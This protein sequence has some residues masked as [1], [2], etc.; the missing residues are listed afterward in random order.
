MA[1][2]DNRSKVSSTGKHRCVR[3]WRCEQ[4]GAR[5][6]NDPQQKHEFPIGTVHKPPNGDASEEHERDPDCGEP[7]DGPLQTW[8]FLPERVHGFNQPCEARVVTG[9][10]HLDFDWPSM[11]HQSCAEFIANVNVNRYRFAREGRRVKASAPTHDSSIGW[12]QL[13]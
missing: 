6:G 5:A 2:S 10:G 11:K 1:T 4:Q 8:R 13:S 9:R 7:L 12:D 3:H